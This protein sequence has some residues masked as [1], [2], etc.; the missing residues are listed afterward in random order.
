MKV[1]K[2]ERVHALKGL[3]PTVRDSLQQDRSSGSVRHS[4]AIYG[5]KLLV[6]CD[7]SMREKA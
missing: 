2:V 7:Q 5:S 1:Y 4:V 3:A 6:F